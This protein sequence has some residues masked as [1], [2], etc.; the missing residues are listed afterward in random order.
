[1][2]AKI[3]GFDVS[4]KKLRAATFSSGAKLAVI[5]GLPASRWGNSFSIIARRSLL[6][7]RRRALPFAI[8]LSFLKRGQ[9]RQDK[10]GV[11]YFNISNRIEGRTD[12]MDIA[13]FE[14]AHHLDNRVTSRMW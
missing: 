7:Y 8:D 14:A 12:V 11:D 1:L 10:L 13:V 6:F 3:V 9:I 5:A 2:Q 4:R